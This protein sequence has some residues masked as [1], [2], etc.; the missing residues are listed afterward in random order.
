LKFGDKTIT[1]GKYVLKAKL[2][3]AQKWHLLIQQNDQTV[4]EVPMAFQKVNDTAELL[5]IDLGEKADGGR[6]LIHWGTLTLASDF[7]KA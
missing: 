1:P 2:I 4:A 5:T 7:E 3:E 6:L